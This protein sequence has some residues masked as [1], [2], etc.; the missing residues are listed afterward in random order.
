MDP[1]ALYYALSTIAQCAAALAALIG[2]FGLWRLDRM[3]EEER[4]IVETQSKLRER[5]HTPAPINERLSTRS[6]AL[7]TQQWWLMLGLSVFL[8][9]TLMGILTPALVGLIF[10]KELLAWAWTPRLLYAASAWLGV[11]PTFMVIVLAWKTM[12]RRHAPIVWA[13]LLGL[14]TP[15]LAATTRCTTYEEKTLGRLQTLCD[16]GTR[17]SARTTGPSTAGTR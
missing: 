4:R 5:G 10:L 1:T 12:S 8:A 7:S 3:R 16:D 14:A 6:A 9:V 15:A 11:A 13:L 17:P 2:F